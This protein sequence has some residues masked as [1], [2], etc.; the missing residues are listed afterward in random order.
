MGAHK[1][2]F[3]IALPLRLSDDD[4]G[5]GE[6]MKKLWVLGLALALNG[7]AELSYAVQHRLIQSDSSS[8]GG[9][10]GRTVSALQLARSPAHRRIVPS[11]VDMKLNVK[12]HGLRIAWA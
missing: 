7:C 2:Q 6:I 11:S 10:A 1:R 12:L 4:P 5:R 9:T 3:D 8:A